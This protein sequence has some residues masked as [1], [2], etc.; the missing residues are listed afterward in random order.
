MPRPKS[1]LPQLIVDPAERAHK[2]RHNKEH[3]ILRGHTRLTIKDGRD[4]LRYCSS[5]AVKFL[6]A[7][8]EEIRS[9]IHQ[10]ESALNSDP[11]QS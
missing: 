9:V 6:Q 8:L 3:Q 7:D 1:F 4:V 2:C 10:L 5:C 11:V